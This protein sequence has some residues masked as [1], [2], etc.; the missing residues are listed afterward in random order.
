MALPPHGRDRKAYHPHHKS[1]GGNAGNEAVA[2][3]WPRGGIKP[4]MPGRHIAHHQSVPHELEGD[5][6]RI[7]E[8]CGNAGDESLV[9]PIARQDG[10]SK[11]CLLYTSDAADE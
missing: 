2:P 1:G 6:Q 8:P 9:E 7:A 10:W 11:P 4:G 3:S 5:A